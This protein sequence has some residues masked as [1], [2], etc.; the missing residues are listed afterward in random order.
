[1]LRLMFFFNLVK[2]DIFIQVD[3]VQEVW[4]RG[5]FIVNIMIR[6]HIGTA[7]VVNV[8]CHT[9]DMYAINIMS[10]TKCEHEIHITKYTS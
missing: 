9:N 7:V 10:K 2:H 6:S 8:F 5:H 3:N 1:M 4:T